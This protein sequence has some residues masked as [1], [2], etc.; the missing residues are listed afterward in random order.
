[1]PSHRDKPEGFDQI[2]RRRSLEVDDAVERARLSRLGAYAAQ[3]RA[4]D[5]A[6]ADRSVAPPP[7][8]PPRPLSVNVF[9]L[10]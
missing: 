4:E 6:R 2:T 10:S 1:M 5:R 8:G 9:G 7:S 3:L